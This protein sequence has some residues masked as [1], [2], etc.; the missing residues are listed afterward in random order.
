MPFPRHSLKEFSRVGGELAAQI[1]A[2]LPP[3]ARGKFL[4]VDIEGRGH[5]LD[6]DEMAATDRLHARL[7]NAQ[8]WV[9]RVGWGGVA[10]RFGGRPVGRPAGSA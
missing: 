10:H 4:A 8:P 2:T 9:V 5:E 1:E 7:D 6:A 3:D